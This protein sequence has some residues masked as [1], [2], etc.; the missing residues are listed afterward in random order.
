VLGEPQV[1]PQVTVN[2]VRA[3]FQSAVYQIMTGLSLACFQVKH[4]DDDPRM[5]VDT[6]F[7]IQSKKKEDRPFYLK[8]VETTHFDHFVDTPR[9]V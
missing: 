5:F 6:Q 3:V 4:A 7:W 2:K 9:N 8:F 1:D